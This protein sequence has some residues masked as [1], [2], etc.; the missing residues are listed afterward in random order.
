MGESKDKG[1]N[2]WNRKQGKQLRKELNSKS[3]FLWKRVNKIDETPKK[4]GLGEET[5]AISGMKK[6]FTDIERSTWENTMNN[7]VI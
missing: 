4:G 7:S 1:L 5:S 2:Q 6:N 3:S